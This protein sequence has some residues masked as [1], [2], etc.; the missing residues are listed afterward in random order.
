M[1]IELTLLCERQSIT[2]EKFRQDDIAWK[3]SNHILNM[4]LPI[5]SS[6]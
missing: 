5:S 2:C 6:Y 1:I 4:H 3:N